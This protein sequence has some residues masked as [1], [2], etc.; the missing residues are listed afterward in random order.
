MCCLLQVLI[1]AL[2]CAA[3]CV[4]AMLY[5]MRVQWHNCK[6]A[7]PDAQLYLQSALYTPPD[8]TLG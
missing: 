3:A 5:I 1:S 7:I 8:C 4:F 6:E 2:E